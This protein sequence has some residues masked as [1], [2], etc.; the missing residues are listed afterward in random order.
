MKEVAQCAHCG[1]GFTKTRRWHKYCSEGCR[2]YVNNRSEEHRTAARN[3]NKELQRAR[4][5][6][7]RRKART[8]ALI[9]YGGNPPV[10]HCPGGCN[11]S[12]MDLLTIDHMD[13]H[14]REQRDRLNRRG[15]AFLD[16]LRKNGFPP[17]YRVFCYNCNCSLGTLGYYPHTKN[18]IAGP[19]PGDH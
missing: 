15:S 19:E 6:R 12:H 16:W 7:S 2:D 18:I 17:G 4:A 14:G 1:R 3:V 11:E 8:Q 10:C 9:H 13:G 5:V